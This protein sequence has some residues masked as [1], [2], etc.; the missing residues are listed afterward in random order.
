MNEGFQSASN[1]IFFFKSSCAIKRYFY[2][3]WK[4]KWKDIPMLMEPLKI[5]G[6]KIK[7]DKVKYNKREKKCGK[8]KWETALNVYISN[9]WPRAEQSS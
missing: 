3:N 9:S 2:T 1:Y 4:P 8:E 6:V 5:K 7:E